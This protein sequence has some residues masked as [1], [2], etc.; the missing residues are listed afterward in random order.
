MNCTVHRLNSWGTFT[1]F[2]AGRQF[3]R[4]TN[5]HDERRQII[6][7]QKSVELATVEHPTR[8]GRRGGHLSRAL[9]NCSPVAMGMSMLAA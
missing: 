2:I 3:E 9:G 4:T 1:R 8:S 6:D 5:I 7:M